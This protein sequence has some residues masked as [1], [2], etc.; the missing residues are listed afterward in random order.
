MARMKYL[1]ALLL[2]C[3]GAAHADRP[4]I[5]AGIIQHDGWEVAL[6]NVQNLCPKG[7]LTLA[8]YPIANKAD[9][10]DGCYYFSGDEIVVKLRNGEM[11]YFKR[12]QIIPASAIKPEL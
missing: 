8:I 10:M 2:V 9:W 6:Y 11:G 5:V 3:T 1:V 12:N 7:A 4:S